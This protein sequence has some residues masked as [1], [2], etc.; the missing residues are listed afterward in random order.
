MFPQSV[1]G[2]TNP[3]RTWINAI[4]RVSK[5]IWGCKE[6]TLGLPKGSNSYGNGRFIVPVRGS[7]IFGRLGYAPLTVGIREGSRS[8]SSSSESRL[9][10]SGLRKL[11]EVRERSACQTRVNGLYD[12]MLDYDLHV[13]AY[14]KIKRNSGSMTHGVDGITLD[15]FSK[16]VIIDTI[17]KLKDHSFRFNPSRRE[18]IPKSNGKLRPLGIPSPRDK[19]VQQVMV[20]I[21]ECLWEAPGEDRFL[22]TSHG[23]RKGRGT[24]TALKYVN[25]WK[26]ISW[27]IE[28]DI[29]SYFDTIDHHV[30]EGLLLRKIDD[31]QFMDLYWKAVRAG[32]V[33]FKENRKVQSLVGAPQGG[34]LSPILSNI[35]LHEFDKWMMDKEP[36]VK[37][38][39]P[40]SVKNKTYL[41]LH[42]RVHTLYRKMNRGK[43]LDSRESLE[44]EVRSIKER[45]KT[46]YKVFG[47]GYR[48]YYCRYADYFLIGINGPERIAIELR[49]QIRLFLG[50]VLKL[51]LSMEK[52]KVTN[53]T[54]ERLLF[55][56]A[57]IYRP[58][59][60]TGESKKYM[61]GREY[62]SRIPA[63]R[64]V[65][66][67]PVKRIVERLA[68]L[69]FCKIVD[70]DQGKVVP[71]GK[72]GWHN[73]SEYDIVV[74]YNAVLQ[75][76]VNYYSFAVNRCRLHFIQ[77]ILQHSCAKLLARKL[78]I[79]SRAKV[80]KKFGESLR[81]YEESERGC[82]TLAL[83]VS[84][85]YKYIGKFMVSPA[86]P[87]DVVYYEV[88]R[89]Y[90]W[91]ARSVHQ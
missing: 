29:R 37:G 44:L 89:F 78:K 28:G 64:L 90:T 60:R 42:S 61:N 35:Y 57:E 55:L 71:M 63:T 30:L 34:V 9:D 14:E 10:Y 40:T 83:K 67:I 38:S 72:T 12:L 48:I 53:V 65:L 54:K 24:H 23:F 62:L 76:L 31:K 5:L 41:K 39:G 20:M 81:I 22:D 19:I 13:A 32:Y 2:D 49:E 85:S 21:L 27:V 82:R 56:G 50:E 16:E 80:F 66:N 59:S 75:G 70:Y 84:R 45:S 33:E 25:S 6:G 8:Y 73:L 69:G 17:G 46:P 11:E 74:R 36:V 47:L 91:S 51:D 15:G 77:F 79:G 1:R 52:T 87:F 4:E 86:E 88:E 3:S 43:V 7:G 58:K 26:S 18:Y 68:N